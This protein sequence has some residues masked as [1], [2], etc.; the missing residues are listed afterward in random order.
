MAYAHDPASTGTARIPVPTRPSV[1]SQYAPFPA[2]GNSASEA[3]RAVS[4]FFTP[5]ACSVAA[6]VSRM[7]YIT[8]FEKNMPERTSV[9]AQA[10]SSSVA[11]RLWA[12]VVLPR[13]L[14]NSTSCAAC[15]KKR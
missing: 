1:K 4:I 7:K 15:Q 2:S 10:S 6:V 9:P 5:C 11:P 14:S 3:C 13:S 12:T 8:R